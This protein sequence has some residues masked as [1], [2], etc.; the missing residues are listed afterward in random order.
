MTDPEFMAELDMDFQHYVGRPSPLYHA[1]RWSRELGGAKIYLKRGD[2][3]DF[4]AK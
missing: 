4:S 1:Q 2:R 3:D